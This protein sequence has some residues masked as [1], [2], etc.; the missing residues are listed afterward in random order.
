[1]TGPLRHPRR[2]WRRSVGRWAAGPAGWSWP[3]TCPRP[4]MC[5]LRFRR[6]VSESVLKTVFFECSLVVAAHK[7]GG[8]GGPRVTHLDS[9]GRILAAQMT[10]V[11]MNVPG[12]MVGWGWWSWGN[13]WRPSAADAR[14]WAW[15]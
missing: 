14:P 3:S 12:W 13:R 2:I 10:S 11:L 5:A 7:T 6:G 4:L 15:A 8:T 1:M 9:T